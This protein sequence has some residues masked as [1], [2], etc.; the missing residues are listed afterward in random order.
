MVRSRSVNSKAFFAFAFA[1][2][3]ADNSTSSPSCSKMFE[4]ISGLCPQ[5]GQ[6]GPEPGGFR[7][8]HF[9]HSFG[10]RGFFSAFGL[11]FPLSN[12]SQWI[13]VTNPKREVVSE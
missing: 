6:T 1:K 13:S 3:L 8:L 5:F 12:L 4:T 9:L 7:K 10:R 2:R 11:S